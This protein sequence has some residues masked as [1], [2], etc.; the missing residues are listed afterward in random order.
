[1]KQKKRMKEGL[2]PAESLNNSAQNCV[3]SG[4]SSTSNSPIATNLQEESRDT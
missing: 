4:T 2:V 3:I 1:M